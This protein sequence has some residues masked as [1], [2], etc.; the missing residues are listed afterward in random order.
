[1]E[2]MKDIQPLKMP[3]SILYVE[4]EDAIRKALSITLKRRVETV[5]TA[6]NGER[7]L[8]MYKIYNPDIIITDVKMPNMNGLEMSKKVRETD[9]ETP[10]ILTTALSDTEY[11]LD[12][13]ETGIN[14]YILKPID[15]NKLFYAIERCYKI[16][17]LKKE[18]Q[19]I[20]EE[21]I[22]NEITLRERNKTMEDDL[23]RAGDLQRELL[24]RKVP[25]FENL[26]IDYRYIPMDN[27][28]GDFFSF[29]PLQ[30]GGIGVFI[31]DVTGHGVSAALFIS[32][33][34]VL[35]DRAC[36]EH[37]KSPKDY[38]R[39]LNNDLLLQEISSFLSAT[40]GL[41]ERSGVDNKCTFTFSIGGHPPPIL[42]RKNMNLVEVLKASG[43]LLGCFKSDFPEVKVKLEKGDRI[44]IY[45]D[46]I[47]EAKTSRQERLG[48]DGFVEILKRNNQ[49]TEFGNLLDKIIEAVDDYKGNR[50]INDDVVL[51]V[52]EIE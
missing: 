40:Y 18:K 43:M 1:M 13:I 10:I 24:P 39:R 38:M 2:E 30:E 47:T 4:D 22:L 49:D 36:R 28:S 19:R 7:G 5:Y 3:I 9:I 16:I 17:E 50:I 45:T 27:V 46:G 52:I 32:L 48:I 12:A 11:F 31:G 33:V 35:T 41:I 23:Q 51:I 8:E 20:E 42:Y 44:F 6:E 14:H 37:A 26:K 21:L 29:T 25:Q 34:K 15:K